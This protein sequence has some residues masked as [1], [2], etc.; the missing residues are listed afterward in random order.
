VMCVVG[1]LDNM[2]LWC[3]TRVFMK[4][5]FLDVISVTLATGEELR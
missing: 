1:L 4:V 3:S 5:I 2:M